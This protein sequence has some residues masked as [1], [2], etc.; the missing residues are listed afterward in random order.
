MR[1]LYKKV[2]LLLFVGAM[3]EILKEYLYYQYFLSLKKKRDLLD[4]RRLIK[5]LPHIED[6]N[7]H[8]N[9]SITVKVR[10]GLYLPIYKA[11]T[12]IL[13]FMSPQEISEINHEAE[14]LPV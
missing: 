10:I 12:S 11:C 14:S 5:L 13:P 1:P 4:L 9:H 7:T 2:T 3:E 6:G 8:F